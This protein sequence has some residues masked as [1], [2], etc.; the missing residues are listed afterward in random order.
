ME[1]GSPFNSPIWIYFRFSGKYHVDREC[2][3][4]YF[5]NDYEYF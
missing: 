5:L 1:I 2:V 3:F 4:I